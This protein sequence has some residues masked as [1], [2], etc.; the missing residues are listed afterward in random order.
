M[1]GAELE[2]LRATVCASRTEQGLPE[3]VEDP[4]VYER[5]SV[6]LGVKRSAA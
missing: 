6:L 5:L 4:A 1:T 3:K 2:R